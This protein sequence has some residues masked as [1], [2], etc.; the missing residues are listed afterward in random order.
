[1]SDSNLYE[2]KEIIIKI[3]QIVSEIL[4]I[5]LNEIKLYDHLINNLNA[6]SLAMFEIRAALEDRF[7]ILIPDRDITNILAINSIVNYLTKKIE[8]L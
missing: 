8:N 6:D 4:G 2:K 1:M 7:N 5:Q 3:K